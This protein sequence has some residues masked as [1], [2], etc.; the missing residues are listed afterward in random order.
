MSIVCVGLNPAI[1]MTMSL[2][3]L[4]LGGVN[5]ASTV[6]V[7]EA[8]KAVNVASML[9]QMKQTVTI[10]GFLGTENKIGFER[11]FDALGINNACIVV[12]GETRQNIKLTE[13]CGRTTEINGEGFLISDSD[14]Q[15]LLHTVIA[16]SINADFVIVSGSLPMGVS[17]DDFKALLLGIKATGTKLVVD[18]SGEALKIATSCEPYLIKPNG[19]ELAQA[20]GKAVMADK[21]HDIEYQQALICTLPPIPHIIVSMGERGVAWHTAKSVLIARPPNIEVVSTVGAGDTLLAGIIAGMASKL[22]DKMIL[23]KA[24][25]MAAHTVS[26]AGVGVAT[27]KRYDSLMA[28]I[29]IHKMMEKV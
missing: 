9:A 3:S 10:T 26:I 22:D 15:A 8:G 28:D 7:H 12:K 18:T 13:L 16:L 17:L 14:K 20:V 5:R 24:T 21:I 23:K 27:K 4:M 6:T 19:N 1:D 11:K 29:T 2:P 25:A